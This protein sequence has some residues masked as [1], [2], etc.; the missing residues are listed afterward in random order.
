MLLARSSLL[1]RLS[2]FSPSLMNSEKSEVS[3]TSGVLQ[4]SK[5]QQKKLRRDQHWEAGRDARKAKRKEKIK[6]KKLQKRAAREGGSLASPQNVTHSN[7]SGSLNRTIAQVQQRKRHQFIQLPI[8]IILDCGFD[9]LMNDKEI[10]SLGSQITRVYSDNHKAPYQ[11][12]LAIS[13]FG[14]HLKE[15][16]DSVLSGNYRSWKNVRFLDVDFLQAAEQA[17]AWMKGEQGGK[18]AG[19]FKNPERIQPEQHESAPESEIVYLS[20]DSPNTLN[21]LR[22]YS[23]YIIGGL[24]DRNRHKGICYKA[25]MNSGVKTAKLPIGD[26]LQMASRFVLATNHVA[27]I[28][29]RWLEVA[30]WGKAFLQVI[31]KRKGGRLK[32]TPPEQR[33][34]RSDTQCDLSS[35]ESVEEAEPCDNDNR[36]ELKK[37]AVRPNGQKEQE[38]GDG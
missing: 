30:D 15:R 9:N 8:T 4:L 5:N 26:Y 13:S 25:A 27:E 36:K 35:F 10:N 2:S 21:E 1:L 17:Q 20:S 28:M 24:V 14:G 34:R 31:P 32:G 6:E 37:G 33:Q 38:Q 19:I 18:M 11:A 7:V 12:H 3:V 23:T 29:L 22:P 16:F